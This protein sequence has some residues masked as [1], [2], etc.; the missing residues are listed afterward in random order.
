MIYSVK[1]KKKIV[2]QPAY[3]HSSYPLPHHR[4]LPEWKS[5]QHSDL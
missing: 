5:T 4:E 3:T 1:S 2:H